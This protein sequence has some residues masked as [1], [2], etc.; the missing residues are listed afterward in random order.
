MCDAEM[1]G[2]PILQVA[3]S[4]KKYSRS[5]ELDAVLRSLFELLSQTL[6]AE[7]AKNILDTIR[8]YV[9]S[10]NPM[11]R[12]E[13]MSELVFEFWPVPPEPGSVADQLIKKGIS[14]GVAREKRNTIRT[15]QAILAMPPSSDEELSGKQLDEL[16]SI[17]ETLQHQIAERIQ[18]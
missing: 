13:K 10:V 5:V 2:E 4:L 6:T 11:V 18:P 9:M 14:Q 15:L 7:R 3:L 1:S 16:Q 12:A 17:I 8:V